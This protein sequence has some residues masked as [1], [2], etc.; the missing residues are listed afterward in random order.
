MV[1]E[2]HKVYS[3]RSRYVVLLPYA[4]RSSCQLLK[5]FA[6]LLLGAAMQTPNAR[7]RHLR[8][9]LLQ[10]KLQKFDGTPAVGTQYL[11]STARE[12]NL[13]GES[14]GLNSPGKFTCLARVKFLGHLAFGLH[15][16]GSLLLFN[17]IA[18]HD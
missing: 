1:F 17:L 5:V 16:G 8:V 11:C 9:H 4:A 3:C 10:A 15:S 14:N 7:I 6:Q 18:V 2:Q 12:S 13:E